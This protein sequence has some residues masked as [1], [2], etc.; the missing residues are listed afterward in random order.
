MVVF[1]HGEPI[2]RAP[3][4]FNVEI[5]TTLPCHTEGASVDEVIT[6]MDGCISR[7]SCPARGGG[8]ES[9]SPGF[10]PLKLTSILQ[11][12]DTDKL[13]SSSEQTCHSPFLRKRGYARRGEG[14]WVLLLS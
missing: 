3:A 13:Q 1:L 9:Q 6:H 11:S 8:Q 10:A 2:E 12:R 4:S 14:Q 7:V 5:A